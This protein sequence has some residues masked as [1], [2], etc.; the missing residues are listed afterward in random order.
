MPSASHVTFLQVEFGCFSQVTKK[1]VFEISGFSTIQKNSRKP[2]SEGGSCSYVRQKKAFILVIKETFRLNNL[3][4]DLKIS[5]F[6]VIKEGICSTQ[7]KHFACKTLDVSDS[8]SIFST[9]SQATKNAGGTRFSKFHWRRIIWSI[10]RT[11][12]TVLNDAV[13]F[14]GFSSERLQLQNLILEN[15]QIKDTETNWLIS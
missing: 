3:L 10:Q 15:Q 9:K 4:D 5:H 6:F 7:K 13:F 12:P 14:P 2:S 1:H 11:W 8:E